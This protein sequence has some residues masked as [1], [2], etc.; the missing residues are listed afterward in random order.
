MEA[1]K[2]KE[3]TVTR[4]HVG[5]VIVTYCPDESA[6][7]RLLVNL[8]PQIDFGVIVDNGS[9]N[10]PQ[11]S[12]L[13]GE[14]NIDLIECGMNLGI[15]AAQ[16]RG[17]VYLLNRGADFVL[18]SDQDSVPAPNM[19]AQLLATFQMTMSSDGLDPHAI[20]EGGEPPASIPVPA[21][22]FRSKPGR[23]LAAVGPVPLDER[24]ASEHALV[25]SF[26]K[27]GP[28]RRRVPAKGE[29]MEVPFV[30]ASGCLISRSALLDVGP[31]NESLFID[32]VDLAWCLRAWDRGY[33]IIVDGSALLQHSLG[34]DKATLAWGREV[35]VQSA[36]RN[37]YMVRNTLYLEAAPFMPVEW[38]LGY[39]SYLVKYLGFYVLVGASHPD[40]WRQLAAG[41]RDGLRGRGR[42]VKKA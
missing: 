17:I 5:A 18:L 1:A 16:N 32:H 23:P 35:H 25:Y 12:G 2:H 7:R 10:S 11:I 6:L 39:L 22:E 15:A 8:A 29:V 14:F 28:K 24:G 37:Y 33:R 13:A 42:N 38:K 4:T 30:L 34:D 20:Q 41:L 40:R 9:T 31:M 26:T 36:M 19:V 21:R 27:W 3:V